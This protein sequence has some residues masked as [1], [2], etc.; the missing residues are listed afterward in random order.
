MAGFFY[1]VIKSLAL[2]EKYLSGLNE[3]IRFSCPAATLSPSI[4]SP[5]DLNTKGV[6]ES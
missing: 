3:R 4:T 1:A 5:Y 6:F 2:E